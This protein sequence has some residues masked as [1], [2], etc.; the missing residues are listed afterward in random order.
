MDTAEIKDMV[1]ARYGTIAA[2]TLADDCEP[3]QSS[4]CG[5]TPTAARKAREMGYS[6]EELAVIPDGANLGLGCG[7]CWPR[8]ARMPQKSA[9][10]MSSFGL[11]IS[12]ICRLQT[13]AR[14]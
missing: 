13:T 14:M 1:R 6:A 10:Q 11:V 2:G 5:A 9:Q 3:T 12:S 7:R 4:C 8:P